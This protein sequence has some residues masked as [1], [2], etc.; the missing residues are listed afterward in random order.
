MVAFWFG[1][2]AIALGF[3]AV[4]G[5]LVW[6]AYVVGCREGRAAGLEDALGGRGWL[7]RG[8]QPDSKLDEVAR[9]LAIAQSTLGR[10]RG[11]IVP[12]GVP[13]ADTRLL[14]RAAIVAMR[15]PS[16][17]Q[18]EAVVPYLHENWEIAVLSCY[19]V[20]VEAAL[21]PTPGP[22]ARRITPE[23]IEAVRRTLLP[24]GKDHHQRV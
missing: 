14:A 3:V 8:P 16:R 20:M 5:S 10:G 23:G 7:A 9:A 1:L 4:M 13:S 6:M 17:E 12:P 11:A 15:I 22:A 2:G 21:D 19:D 24:F 18:V